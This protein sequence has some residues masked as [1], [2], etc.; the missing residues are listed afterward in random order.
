MAGA[1]GALA[2]FTYGEMYALP[3]LLGVTDLLQALG[4]WKIPAPQAPPFR[5]R[6]ILW[7]RS[8]GIGTH[9]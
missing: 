6:S 7:R 8:S 5:N 4:E 2:G 3:R 9:R 1:E